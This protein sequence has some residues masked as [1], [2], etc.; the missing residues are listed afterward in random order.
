MMLGE[1]IAGETGLLD[2]LDQP[3]ALIEEAAQWRAVR[4]EV[5]EDS[6]SQHALFSVTK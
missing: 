4:V 5:V 2:Q 1:M 6:K 3:Q